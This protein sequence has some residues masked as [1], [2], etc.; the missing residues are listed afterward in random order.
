MTPPKRTGRP[1]T[2]RQRRIEALR[3][4]AATREYGLAPSH[5]AEIIPAYPKATIR[6]LLDLGLVARSRPRRMIVTEKGR[7]LLD[8]IDRQEKGGPA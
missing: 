5:F 8:A 3:L 6:A 7:E 1:L 2:A 4:L